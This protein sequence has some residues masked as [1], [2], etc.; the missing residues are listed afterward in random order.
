MTDITI[1]FEVG[2]HPKVC[3]HCGSTDLEE[4]GL[5][6]PKCKDCGKFSV[7][8]LQPKEE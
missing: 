6:A 8:H 5:V 2:E 7:S 1:E 4:V 3:D